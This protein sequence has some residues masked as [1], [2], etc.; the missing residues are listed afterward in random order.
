MLSPRAYEKGLELAW[1]IDKALPQRVIGDEARVRQVLL[2]LLSN[3]V[4]FTD[5]GGIVVHVEE[6]RRGRRQGTGSDRG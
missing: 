4:K 5:A 2:N 3:A 1:T 6:R